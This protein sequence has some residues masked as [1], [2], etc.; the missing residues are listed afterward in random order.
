VHERA[1]G[2]RQPHQARGQ[3]HVLQ[4]DLGV[5]AQI[6][7]CQVGQRRQLLLNDL[8]GTPSAENVY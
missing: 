2:E 1:G 7:T 8:R 4:I 5:H 3:R 6:K